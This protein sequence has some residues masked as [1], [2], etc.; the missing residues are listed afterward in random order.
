MQLLSKPQGQMAI[1][2][3][4]FPNTFPGIIKSILVILI[5]KIRSTNISI[6]TKF[7]GI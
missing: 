4:L 2:D 7:V 3:Q 5:Q 6:D 1:R